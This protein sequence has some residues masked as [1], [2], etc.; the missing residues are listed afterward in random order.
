[1][2]KAGHL[3]ALLGFVFV[4]GGCSGADDDA[5]VDDDDAVVDDDDA[6]VDDDDTAGIECTPCWGNYN[7]ENSIDLDGVRICESIAGSLWIYYASGLTSLDLPCLTTVGAGL[8]IKYTD[9]LTTIDLPNL[10]DMG[11]GLGIYDNATLTSIDMPVLTSVGAGL[12]IR[13]ND[14]LTSLE[15]LSSLTSVSVALWIQDNACLSQAEA[16]A[17]AAGVG[18]STE[19][20]YGNGANYPCP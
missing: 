6:V 11:A 17:F 19:F 14:A 9:S 20:V 8:E 1:M 5:V 16:E 10:T 12:T 3:V 18:E 13:E 2:L 4:V 15:G 7:I